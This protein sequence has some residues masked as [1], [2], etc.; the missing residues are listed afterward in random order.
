MQR[1]VVCAV[2]VDALDDID[3]SIVRP[4]RA[5]HPESWPGAM[6]ALELSIHRFIL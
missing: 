3:F 5:E 4:A 2:H 6:S 1:D